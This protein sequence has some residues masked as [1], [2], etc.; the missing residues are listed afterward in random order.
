MTT[1]PIAT[2]RLSVADQPGRVVLVTIGHP[3]PDPNPTGDWRCSFYIEGI[4]DSGP[5]VVHGADSLQALLIAL[6]GVRK[7]LDASGLALVWQNEEPGNICIPR[8]VPYQFGG[9]F[10]RDI[11]RYIDDR[12][13]AFAS[14]AEAARG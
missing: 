10:A 12:V 3:E 6:E 8:M 14:A 1:A 2:R 4:D 7:K 13:E 9:T 11:E 5:R